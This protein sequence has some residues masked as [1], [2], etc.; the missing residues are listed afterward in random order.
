MKGVSMP[1]KFLRILICFPLFLF[2]TSCKGKEGEALRIEKKI[3]I[4]YSCPSLANPFWIRVKT[5]IE[6]RARELGNGNIEIITYE[7]YDNVKKQSEDIRTLITKDKVDAICVSPY[8][9]SWIVPAIQEALNA[10]IPVVVVDIGVNMVR[11]PTIIS[12]N[13]AGGRMAAEYLHRKLGKGAKVLH[14]RAQPGANNVRLRGSG[15]LKEALAK[16]LRIC[17]EQD[18]YS[19]R[20]LSYRLVKDAIK[21]YPDIKGI[22]CQNDEMALGA[23]KALEEEGKAGKVVVVG[24]DGNPEAIEAI[25]AGKLDAT[26]VQHPE[27]MG[28]IG[29]ETAI[30]AMRGKKVEE[31]RWIPVE[32]FSKESGALK[33]K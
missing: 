22:F 3:K 14:I 5:G 29:L 24:F 16:G 20:D 32:L 9:S 28:R 33:S 4:G 1:A 18:G 8:D 13:E 17:A 23:L 19:R 25:K 26:I 27:E 30:M 15:F 10:K 12:D 21:R 6:E 11:V 7:A 2:I 31:F